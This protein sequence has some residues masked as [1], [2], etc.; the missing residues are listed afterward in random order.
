MVV[1]ITNLFV[2]Q[3]VFTFIFTYGLQQVYSSFIVFVVITASL[4]CL[5]VVLQQMYKEFTAELPWIYNDFTGS[6]QW[7]CIIYYFVFIYIYSG[8][9]IKFTTSLKWDYQQ[10]YNRFTVS[11][12]S[13]SVGLLPVYR[14]HG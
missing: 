2:W 7:A 13:L 9:I 4:K 6:L 10:V 1:S 11:F 14:V 8:F 3:R 5:L 12:Q